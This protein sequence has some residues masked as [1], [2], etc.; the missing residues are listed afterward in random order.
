MATG[1]HSIVSPSKKSVSLTFLGT[2]SFPIAF[3]VKI[4]LLKNA[5]VAVDCL[6]N[7]PCNVTSPRW[8]RWCGPNS[9][10]WRCLGPAHVLSLEVCESYICICVVDLGFPT[11]KTSCC[12]PTHQTSAKET[13]ESNGKRNP[14]S[15]MNWNRLFVWFTSAYLFLK[16]RR[17][18]CKYKRM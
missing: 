13:T 17:Q 9:F 5:L 2:V 6:T 12:T 14:Q 8:I 10:C 11:P 18:F 1:A 3:L 4:K 7:L 15:F 16:H